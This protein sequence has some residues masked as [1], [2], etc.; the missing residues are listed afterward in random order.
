[1]ILDLFKSLMLYHQGN[2]D[3]LIVSLYKFCKTLICIKY[4]LV[5][6]LMGRSLLDGDGNIWDEDANEDETC[7][8]EASS[9]DRGNAPRQPRG[10]DLPGG[11]ADLLSKGLDPDGN[12]RTDR[13]DEIQ[14]VERMISEKGQTVV[15]FL[16]VDEGFNERDELMLSR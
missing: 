11:G 8:A 1:M 14:V 10:V 6:W 4:S 5:D 16:N 12:S 13:K 2:I 7:I 3:T 9:I 15:V